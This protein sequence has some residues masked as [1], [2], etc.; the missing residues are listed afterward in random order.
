MSMIIF[1]VRI[2]V[3]DLVVANKNMVFNMDII[4]ITNGGKF[5]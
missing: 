3:M 5:L 2:T 4:G 1:M